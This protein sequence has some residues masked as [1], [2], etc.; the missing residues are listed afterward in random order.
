MNGKIKAINNLEIGPD[1][2]L[3][4]LK[5]RIE[6]RRK[7][8]ILRGEQE[9]IKEGY[10]YKVRKNAAGKGQNLLALQ[11]MNVGAYMVTPLLLGVLLGSYIDS[12][13]HIRPIA[14]VTLIAIGTGAM[15]YNLF[16]LIKKN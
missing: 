15:F 3:H 11:Y 2:E 9:G 14:T 10:K 12:T 5:K 13:F 7:K 4:A 6:E 16:R 8:L 1:F